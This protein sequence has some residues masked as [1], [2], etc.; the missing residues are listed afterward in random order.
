MLRKK[1]SSANLRVRFEIMPIEAI[2]ILRNIRT[3]ITG[4]LV[5]RASATQYQYGLQMLAGVGRLTPI[6]ADLERVK[7]IDGFSAQAEKV[8]KFFIYETYVKMPGTFPV[9]V[10]IADGEEGL[11]LSWSVNER[12]VRLSCRGEAEQENYLYY[13]SP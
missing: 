11:V 10:F 2:D 8:A 7:K 1:S 12:Q 6:I 13:E 5:V 9:P 3:E 4:S